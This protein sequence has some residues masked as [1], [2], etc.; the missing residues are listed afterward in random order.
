MTAYMALFGL[1][2]YRALQNRSRLGWGLFLPVVFFIGLRH[3]VGGDWFQ[4]LEIYEFF[5]EK[6]FAD[7]LQDSEPGYALV[8]AM[9][10]QLGWGAHG[11]NLICSLVFTWGLWRFCQAQPLPVLA[12]VVAIPY[13]ITVVAMGYTRQSVAIGLGMAAL[14]SLERLQWLQFI[15]L[16]L[17][18][19]LFHKTAVVLFGVGILLTSGGWWWRVPL[20]GL[21]GFL[22]YN[23]ILADSVDRYILNYELASYQS[24]G[25]AIRVAMNALP[26]LVFLILRGRMSLSKT[27]LR[28]WSLIAY[29]S[30]AM[31]LALLVVN[32]S[33]AVDRLALYLIPIQLFV[34]SRVPVRNGVIRPIWV[35][36]VVFYSLSVL[37]VWLMF[38]AH[39]YAWLPYRFYPLTW[40]LS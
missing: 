5:A 3:E 34:W 1:F 39:A 27:Q 8:N 6:S 17:L 4:Y 37:L 15:G 30:L 23:A 38:A 12:L 36:G 9:S 29:A 18:A 24:Q 19:A 26:S 40:L 22:A 32:S 33:T 28:M 21:V 14:L 16:V 31:M 10:Y 13:L 20:M 2:A 11:T 35:Q 25:A 7:L